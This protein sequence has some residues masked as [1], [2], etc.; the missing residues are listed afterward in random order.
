MFSPQAAMTN[1]SKNEPEVSEDDITK[2]FREVD[3]DKDGFISPKEAKR[4]YKRLSK[5]LGKENDKE[6]V[7]R[8]IETADYDCDGR[9]SL[10]EFKLSIAG[11]TLC[12]D[13]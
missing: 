10:E 5:L 9:I 3:L 6:I 1:M 2:L 4:A 11:N 12:D 7:N 13:V 8:W